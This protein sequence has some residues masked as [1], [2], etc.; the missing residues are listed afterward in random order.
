[1]E[2]DVKTIVLND[3]DGNEIEFEVITKLDIE[4][5]EYVIVA[6]LDR[7]DDVDAV[8]LKIEQDE[9]GERHEKDLP[10]ELHGTTRSVF[11]IISG[12]R[13]SP[14]CAAAVRFTVKA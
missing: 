5:S 2:Q 11:L 6:P 4:D 10:L 8:A 3:E 13:T 14:D 9:N 1:M 7:D 12:E